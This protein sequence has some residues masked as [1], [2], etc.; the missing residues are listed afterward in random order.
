MGWKSALIGC[1]QLS[2]GKVYLRATRKGRAVDYTIAFRSSRALLTLVTV[3]ALIKHSE[4]KINLFKQK[5]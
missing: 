4:K 2:S 1:V 3:Y 5:L